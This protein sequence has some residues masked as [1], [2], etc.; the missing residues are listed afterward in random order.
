MNKSNNGKQPFQHDTVIPDTNPVEAL[1]GKPQS[2]KTA[3]GEQKG[4]KD[5]LEKRGFDVSGM[6]AKCSPVCSIENE[7][8]CMARLLSSQADVK[9]QV[10]LLKQMIVACGH[11]CMFLLKFHC[12]L[13]PIEM[14][15]HIL[16]WQPLLC[17]LTSFMLYSVLG[18][19]KVQIP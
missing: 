5:V 10:S 3:D 19:G 6:R 15:S 4:L 1:R 16:F 13:N 14:V 2:I 11:L 12:K 18:V 8:C 17:F 9:N 7:H